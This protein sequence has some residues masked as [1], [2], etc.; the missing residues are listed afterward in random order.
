M[1]IEFEWLEIAFTLSEKKVKSAYQK[2]VLRHH[3]GKGGTGDDFRK[4]QSVM[5]RVV[6]NLSTLRQIH[7]E[8]FEKE[9]TQRTATGD[10][11][12]WQ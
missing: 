12:T 10:R 11:V 9:V 4:T 8:A 5:E 7:P 3:P 1:E 2:M 6:A